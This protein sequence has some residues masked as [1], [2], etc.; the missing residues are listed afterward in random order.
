MHVWKD[1][2]L[3]GS[4]SQGGAQA[5]T[6]VHGRTMATGFE[7]LFHSHTHSQREKTV[8]ERGEFVSAESLSPPQGPHIF[9]SAGTDPP[10]TAAAAAAGPAPAAGPR[11]RR[12]APGGDRT[13][14]LRV[15]R[16]QGTPPPRPRPLQ[17]GEHAHPSQLAAGTRAPQV[18]HPALPPAAHRPLGHCHLRRAGRPGH[19]DW[20]GKG[21]TRLSVRLALRDRGR[22]E[23][24]GES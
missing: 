5:G 14:A 12:Q 21:P 3:K 13:Q 8:R 1:D 9:L 7:F 17:A 2:F 23:H 20:E 18:R 15:Q 24:Q 10:R 6:R 19:L 4:L 16:D 22:G 11:A